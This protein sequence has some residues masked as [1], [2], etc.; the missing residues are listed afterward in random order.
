MAIMDKIAI[1]DSKIQAMKINL[2]LPE[3]ASLDEVVE[4]TAFGGGGSTPIKSNIYKV[5]TLEERDAII[6]MVEGDMCVVYD[7]VIDNATVDSKFQTAIFPEVVVLDKAITEY[8]DVRYGAVDNNVMFDC[9]GSL[10]SSSF[11]MSCYT[12]SSEISI[13]Y[14]SSDG[15]RYT[16]TDTTGNPVDFTTEIYY[17]MPEMWDD[18]IGHFIQVG[19]VNFDGIFQY[20][21]YSWNYANI[22]I[23][24]I[25][26]Y[27][28]KNCRAYTNNGIA[29]GTL[30]LDPSTTL[31]DINAKLY[32]ELSM[33][34][35]NL[36]EVTAPEDSS[37]LYRMS[38]IYII[39]SK[40]NGKSLLNTSNVT[41]MYNMFNNC[42]SLT[43]ISQLDTSKVTNMSCMFY[44]CD[45]LTAIPQLDT[46]S[47]T[48][49][50]QMF[51]GC[52]SLTTIPQLDTH[53]VTDMSLMFRGCNSLITVP[54]LNIDKVIHINQMFNGCTS[55]TSIPQLNT[56]N[57][58]NAHGMFYRCT[59][60]TTIPQLNTSKITNMKEMFYTCTS[61]TTMPQLDTNKV[62]DMIKMFYG[63]T[64]LTTIPQLDTSNVTSMQQMFYNCTSLTSIPQLNTSKVK[65][66]SY[67]LNYCSNLTTLGGFTNLGQAYDTTQKA[68]YIYYTLSLRHS[69]N[70]THDS[71]INVLNNLYDIAAK[72]CK[73]QNL[74][75]GSTNL[76][77]LTEEEIAIA[78]NKGWTVS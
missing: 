10:D 67:I 69:N 35:N 3:D 47:V 6:D 8:V 70:L 33:L 61:L 20:K 22:N 15:T 24:T 66:M 71:L 68:N 72:G 53:N 37:N 78:T 64:S 76:E 1:I 54:L 13:E 58:T 52:S 16:R 2:G 9:W 55:L 12:E 48:N 59:S 49:M 56:S 57:A 5:A 42:K 25:N 21:D 4:T 30:A 73:T 60:L 7:S 62:T 28:Y 75:L 43:T 36:D 77:K 46:S 63:C 29:V 31:D 18:V 45:K 27:I 11:R 34:Y 74:E 44:N 41:N 14:T 38:N 23:P 50:Q 51:E 26:D 40:I 19:S 39:P 17:N 32:S 65:D